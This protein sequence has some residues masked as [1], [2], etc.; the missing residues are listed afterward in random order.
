MKLVKRIFT[1]VLG[2]VTITGSMIILPVRANA[3]KITKYYVDIDTASKPIITTPK[4]YTFIN[5]QGGL[6]TTDNPQKA[7]GQ[8]LI[9]SNMA[10][11][12]TTQAFVSSNDIIQSSVIYNTQVR[13]SNNTIQTGNNSNSDAISYAEFTKIADDKMLELVNAHRVAN[14]A[15]T[16]EWDP[17]LAETSTEKSQHMVDHNYMEHSYKGISTG[18]VQEIAWK[19]NIDSENCLAN[20][21]YAITNTGAINLATAMF[22]QWKASPGHNENMLDSTWKEFG[23]GFSFSNGKARYESY[24]TQQFALKHDGYDNPYK[25]WD[26][27]KYVSTLTDDRFLHGINEIY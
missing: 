6:S 22:N 16:L 13:K 8:N 25:M 23:F 12:T 14:G 3:E 11:V 18:C 9:G 5:I 19:H 15:G 20:Y 7:K 26:G 21:S 1:L 4:K 2:I 17:I 24:G 10:D 27:E